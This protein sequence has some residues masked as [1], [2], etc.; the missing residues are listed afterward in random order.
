M[1]CKIIQI[2]NLIGREDQ[3]F[4]LKNRV[5][6]PVFSDFLAIIG[7]ENIEKVSKQL[8][9]D[10]TEQKVIIKETNRVLKELK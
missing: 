9:L 7:E 2:N 8:G 10:E 6:N 5:S 4:Q 1:I 3:V